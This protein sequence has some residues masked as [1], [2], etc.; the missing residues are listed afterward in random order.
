[1]KWIKRNGTKGNENEM[2]IK[3]NETKMKMKGNKTKRNE[4]K[5]N[6]T[7][8]WNEMKF[9][10]PPHRLVMNLLIQEWSEVS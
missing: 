1:M 9:Y 4:M 7:K 10:Y 2:K 6:E 8:G 5:W 3:W